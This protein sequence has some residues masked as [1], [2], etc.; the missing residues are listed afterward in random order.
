MNSG[1]ALGAAIALMIAG[2]VTRHRFLAWT[3]LAVFVLLVT[4]WFFPFW[5][6]DL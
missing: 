5:L 6:M 1:L 3:G 2:S 4:G